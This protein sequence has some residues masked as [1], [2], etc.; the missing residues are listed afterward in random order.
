MRRIVFLTLIIS[1]LIA[2]GQN[3]T[4]RGK[5]IDGGSGETLISVNVI[6]V[7]KDRGVPTDLDGNFSI[8]IEPGTYDLKFSYIMYADYVLKGVEVKSGEV[9]VI[10]AVSMRDASD[11]L[12]V[13]V[14]TAEHKK[15]GVAQYMDERKHST[16]AKDGITKDEMALTD[17]GNA[18]EAAKRV[19]GVSVEGGKYV[20]VRGLGDRYTKTTLNGL[21]IPGLDPDRNS[22]QLDLFPTAL[23]ENLIVSKN[24]S[25]PNPADYT[26]GLVNIETIG[27]PDKKFAV[28]SGSI[29]INPDMHFNKNYLTYQGGKTDYLGFDDGTRALP[30]LALGSNPPSPISG[31]TP[32]QVNNFVKSFSPTLG[33]ER[34]MSPMDFSISYSMGDQFEMGRKNEKNKGKQFGYIF[35]ASYKV[36]Y[37]YFKEVENSEYL[38]PIESDLYEM[39]Y[40]TITTGE[41]S[42]RNV[43]IGLLG[44]I[45][46]KTKL[47]KY[48]V[49]LMHLQNS[50]STAGKFDIDN[51][52]NAVGQSGYIAYSD[53]L[54][55][56]Q[57]GLSNLLISGEHVIDTT[58][59]RIN[60]GV[61]PTFSIS[62]DP[63]VRKT[64]YTVGSIIQFSAGGG[65]MPVRIWR[66]LNEINVPARLDATKKYKMFKRDANLRFGTSYTYKRRDY[67][68]LQY[69]MQFWY[70]QAWTNNPETGRPEA[71]DVLNANNI[72]PSNPNGIYYQ[73]GINR[74]N[75]NSY[76]SAVNNTGLY[77]NNEF[78]FSKSF[79]A[80]L[81]VRGE[82]F[83][84]THW[85]RDQKFASGDTIN[86][87]SLNGDKVINQVDFFPEVNLIYNIQSKKKEEV[88]QNIRGSYSMSIAR[89]SFKELSYA[90]IVDPIT[91]RI[92]TG[93]LFQ[94]ADWDG[95]LRSTRIHNADLRWE[96]FFK[97]G[98]IISASLFYKNFDAPIELVRIPQQTT[99][100]E[101]QPRNV[102]NA[103]LAGFEVEFRKNFG[104]IH[105]SVENLSINC[106]L[107]MV[108]SE[109]TMTDA[110]FNARKIYEKWDEGLTPRRQMAGQSPWLVNAG[111]VYSNKKIGKDKDKLIGID[112][113][114][115]YN[116]KGPTLY[117]V[118][119]GIFPDIY[120]D[121]YHSLNMSFNISFGKNQNT[122]I[123]LSADNLIGDDRYDYYSSY[124]A[125]NQ[126]F[127]RMLP[128]RKF[129]IGFKYKFN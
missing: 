59:W 111:L 24:F 91:Q 75:P 96:M 12:G 114:I 6:V 85:G 93:G 90:Q 84:Q 25:A 40:A 77:I 104:F 71:S 9:T 92:F 82:Y 122:S 2:F 102:G 4:I 16:T 98:Q 20:Y 106:N 35:S 33:A 15:G 65:G 22:L 109:V 74:P 64:A 76:Q 44:G 28:L 41:L 70:P 37:T 61:S 31:H 54:E 1:N 78:P 43:L 101:Y 105:K 10:P 57:R 26:G 107:T 110:E 63:D 42:N 89:P 81:G 100:T 95:N 125:Q 14:V 113:G 11:S 52:G 13:V 67:E 56:N 19:T 123:Q 97:R 55:F 47:S 83:V 87:K 53:N 124:G 29:G 36:D 60:W 118:G 117:I 73:S 62:K 8:S 66:N 34:A 49:T 86:G 45:A 30:D 3:G 69:N 126:T 127:S 116:V 88:S 27:F 5:V 7:D 80:V 129:T 50:E 112:A 38:K 48:R 32:T 128:G 51:N 17:D 94:F 72:Y 108:K 79:K 23:I 120:T 39:D 46:V 58:G 68:I 18:A 103:W 99:T 21:E 115:F 121:S 119:T